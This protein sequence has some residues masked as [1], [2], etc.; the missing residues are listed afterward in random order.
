MAGRP[1]WRNPARRAWVGWISI[2]LALA[3]A[4]AAMPSVAVA[5]VPP[6]EL[7]TLCVARD[8]KVVQAASPA[9]CKGTERVVRLPQD[10]PTHLC[11]RDDFGLV[12]FTT[13]PGA[14]TRDHEFL[15]TIPDHGPAILCSK[16]RKNGRIEPRG[17]LR[18]AESPAGCD[19]AFYTPFVTPAAPVAA[20][21]V[22]TVDED[23]LLTVA[24]RGVLDN[25]ADVT[26]GPL[27][28]RLEAAPTIGPLAL[29]SDGSFAYD[30]RGLFDDLDVDQSRTVTFTYATS[31]GV[32]ESELATVR[33]TVTGRND[34]PVSTDDA[35]TTD[36]DTTLLVVP[37][38]VLGNDTDA[39]TTPLSSHVVEPP[40]AGALELR[41]DGGVTYTPA[42]AF[43]HLGEGDSAGDDFTYVARDGSADSRLTTVSLRVTGVNDAPVGTD[44]AF[45]TDENTALVLTAADLVA[46]DHDAEGDPLAAAEISAGSPSSAFVVQ[47]DGTVAFDP[48]TDFDHL[49]DGET[50]LATFTYK[51]DDGTDT[52]APTTVRINVTGVS[53]ALATDD[54]AQTSED[55]AVHIDVLANDRVAGATLT[56]HPLPTTKGTATA[57]SGFVTYDPAGSFEHLT[58]GQSVIDRFGYV[59][60]NEEGESRLAVVTVVVGGVADAPVAVDDRYNVDPGRPVVTDAADGVLFNDLDPDTPMS[61]L[62]AHLVAPPERGRLTLHPD[63]GFTFDPAGELSAEDIV[64]FR[65]RASDGTGESATGKVSL[66]VGIDGPP[67]ILPAVYDLFDDED[68]L[69]WTRTVAASDPE[70]QPLTFRLEPP[71][72]HFTIDAATGE[73]RLSGGIPA[74]GSYPLTVVVTDVQGQTDGA[75]IVVQVKIRF[76][77][78]DDVYDAIGNTLLRAGPSA[79]PAQ[80]DIVMTAADGVLANDGAQDGTLV[81]AQPGTLLSDLGGSVDLQSDGSFSYG[82]PRPDPGEPRVPDPACDPAAGQWDGAVPA[83]DGFTYEV[84]DTD[85][86]TTQTRTATLNIVDVVWYVDSGATG[87]GCGTSERP[88]RALSSLSPAGEDDDGPGQAVYLR[89]TDR[90][91]YPTGLVLEDDQR[92]LGEGTDLVVGGHLLQAAGTHPVIA[93]PDG[94]HLALASGNRLR[95]FT[96]DSAGGGLRGTAIGNAVI[97]L[98]EVVATGG[99]ALD[100]AGGSVAVAIGQTSSTSATSPAITLQALDG[101]VQLG[102]V[103]AAGAMVVQQHIGALV[104]DTATL[105]GPEGLVV[106][107][108]APASSVAVGTVSTTVAGTGISVRDSH[109]RVDVSSLQTAGGNAGV[110]VRGGGGTVAILA[111]TISDPAQRGITVSGHDGAVSIGDGVVAADPG[112]FTGTLLEVADSSGT[113][114]NDSALHLGAADGAPADGSGHSLTVRG[115][116]GG[117]SVR[118]TAPVVDRAAGIRV[119]DN[120]GTT[121]TELAGGMDVSTNA[122]P[123]FVAVSTP[124][125]VTPPA[126]SLSTTGGTALRLSAVTIAPQGATW[127]NVSSTDAPFVENDGDRVGYG[128]DLLGVTPAPGGA[129]RLVVEGGQITGPARGGVRAVSSTDL[130]VGALTVTDSQATGIDLRRTER[131]VLQG[132]A[133]V[134]AAGRGVTSD[135]D[136]DLTLDDVRVTDAD[137]KGIHLLDPAGQTTLRKSV[138]SGSRDIGLHVDDTGLAAPNAVVLEGTV[139]SD[140]PAETIGIRVDARDGSDLAVRTVGT[141]PSG[142]FGGLHALAA[143]ATGGAAL[144][145]DIARF[146][147]ANPAEDGILLSGAGRD[148]GGA[149]TDVSFTIA[150]VTGAAGGGI[151]IPGGAGLHAV[152]SGG[153]TVGGSVARVEVNGAK[154]HG[155]L[156][157]G[158]GPVTLSQVTVRGPERIGLAV[159]NSHSIDIERL[160]VEGAPAGHAVELW[161]TRDVSIRQSRVDLRSLTEPTDDPDNPTRSVTAVDQHCTT[162]TNAGEIEGPFGSTI[163]DPLRADGSA[164]IFARHVSGYL[165]ITDT[166]VRGA[167]L[168]Q[169][170]VFNGASI[171]TIADPTGRPVPT[172][173]GPAPVL[174]VAGLLLLD[175]YDHRAG[176]FAGAGTGGTLRLEFPPTQTRSEGATMACATDGG[177]VDV[178]GAPSLLVTSGEP[179]LILKS[180]DDDG[181]FVPKKGS[182]LVYDLDGTHIEYADGTPASSASAIQILSEGGL[183]FG[184]IRN[185]TVV[186]P[187]GAGMQIGSGQAIDGLTVEDARGPGVLIEDAEDVEVSRLVVDDPTEDGVR[188]TRSTGV[189]IIDAQISRPG[190]AGFDVTDSET[191]ALVDTRVEGPHDPAVDAGDVAGLTVTRGTYTAAGA[192][193]SSPRPGVRAHNAAPI[194][195]SDVTVGGFDATPVEI[196]VGSTYPDLTLPDLPCTAAPCAATVSLATLQTSNAPAG[197]PAVLIGGGP[198]ATVTVDLPAAASSSLDAP[199]EVISAAGD[200]TVQGAPTIDFVGTGDGLRAATEGGGELAVHLDGGAIAFTPAAGAIPGAGISTSGASSTRVAAS[201][202]SNSGTHGIAVDGGDLAVTG[203]T[204]TTPGGNGVDVRGTGTAVITDTTITGAGGDGIVGD[205]LVSLTVASSQV[206]S[207]G[208]SGVVATDVSTVDVQALTVTDPGVNGLRV[209][210]S[211]DVTAATVTVTGATGDAIAVTGSTTVAVTG[212]H[213]T[214]TAAGIRIDGNGVT[215]QCTTLVGNDVAAAGD[216]GFDLVDTGLRGYR[217]SPGTAFESVEEWLD[218]NANVFASVRTSNAQPC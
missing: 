121:L 65:Y 181:F 120:A 58:A 67:S 187:P 48:G 21:D 153:A 173:V 113:V 215:G 62:T 77:P 95:G 198:G 167:T 138:I 33:I 30:P 216:V 20:D 201:A 71:S 105:T 66:G 211:D 43:D 57:D 26:G 150:D 146:S 132:T 116:S 23:S 163:L 51:A 6:E 134:R 185:T 184:T 109:G 125:A 191:V 40:A 5:D 44:D 180:A 190:G 214:T 60:T 209:A 78:T 137:G 100:L 41:S 194:S 79:P 47:P 80:G 178:R 72:P 17:E 115:L 210:A 64:E 63:G 34:V 158:V 45:T 217:D 4:W 127:R 140:T 70:G 218:R 106:Q 154:G 96:V 98:P 122:V 179:A 182:L 118:Q 160:D 162:T 148:A 107:A 102:T 3:M 124:L 75:E 8:D 88:F 152:S 130:T 177:V 176:L 29:L 183:I 91:A 135:N 155:L 87:P 119:A 14:C 204:I 81:I 39:E 128:V 93:P 195:L 193:G 76:A 200:V 212:A 202:I 42:G 52:S 197:G 117:A 104:M 56:V 166:T 15:L 83:A 61:G 7:S 2:T 170:V 90:A 189:R 169:I 12:R 54:V 50:G 123:A 161:G 13:D 49:E 59:L 129:G 103:D 89:G 157:E 16:N 213:A 101:S 108:A 32:L 69:G 27:T 133:V 112:A 159:R 164:G 199:L 144:D 172:L 86:G 110:E 85:S 143:Y 203:T 186:S 35:Y 68:P 136:R 10:R 142:S 156:L 192:A 9:H 174:R 22:Y 206:G 165:E 82:P 149:P 97:D 74:L 73:L 188:I 171:P 53:A 18:Y 151:Q 99:P 19:S 38:G 147:I 37:P 28:A 31:D 141:L 1:T 84:L 111:A 139:V 46:N 36:E 25:D 207:A 55:D 131:V 92:L 175:A 168:H 11:A 94:Q 126:N 196:V 208:A 24:A 205:E 114:L 145:V